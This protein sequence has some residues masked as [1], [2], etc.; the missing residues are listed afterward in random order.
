MTLVV[1][2]LVLRA[3]DAPLLPYLDVMVL[4]VLVAQMVGRL[5]CLMA[6]CCHGRPSTW[7]VCYGKEYV[8]Q[9]GLNYLSGVR[10]WPVQVA[11]SLALLGLFVAAI[12]VL[13]SN[14]E[15]GTVAATYV[16][17]YAAV[18]FY[19]EP[20]RGDNRRSFVGAF[21]EAQWVGLV[22]AAAVLGAGLWTDMV[23]RWWYWLFAAAVAAAMVALLIG[24]WLHPF[25]FLALLHP[26][27][28]RELVIAIRW[29]NEMALSLNCA[30]GTSAEPAT[31]A[32]T[33]AGLRIRAEC[34]MSGRDRVVDY[35]FSYGRRPLSHRATGRLDELTVLVGGTR[36][37]TSNAHVQGSRTASHGDAAPPKPAR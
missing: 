23:L 16:G 24:R 9:R 37:G 19:L 22:I 31:I 25:S 34:R 28:L 32:T 27:E 35:E 20:M 21:S 29:V 6:G 14:T 7:G 26:N 5:G 1:V 4:G 13:A 30:G 36:I 8:K 12:G 11:E 3:V 2:V 15:A 17:G 33:S 18:R 10:L